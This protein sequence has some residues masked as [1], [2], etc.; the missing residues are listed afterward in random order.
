MEETL[1]ENLEET[2]ELCDIP[3][4]ATDC[5]AAVG[6]AFAPLLLT[7]QAGGAFLLACLSESRGPESAFFWAGVASVL[8]SALVYLVLQH[9][10][11]ETSEDDQGPQGPSLLSRLHGYAAK[12]SR[13]AQLYRDPVQ[14]ASFCRVPWLAA[15]A[16][17]GLEMSIAAANG[18]LLSFLKAM[19]CAAAAAFTSGVVL[20]LAVDGRLPGP[21]APVT[22]PET[23]AATI[24]RCPAISSCVSSV[25]A[26]ALPAVQQASPSAAEL[27]DAGAGKLQLAEK[28]VFEAAELR[29]K[30]HRRSGK[31]LNPTAQ[32]EK[33]GVKCTVM[34][35]LHELRRL[36]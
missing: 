25:I 5:I 4:D 12:L 19:V 23:A 7:L 30:L 24:A 3:V 15:A 11:G 17:L 34:Y 27:R 1:K 36:C 20:G 10:R 28:Y 29:D 32:L 18:C 16:T 26:L 6:I 22:Y 33:L 31:V 8:W 2:R 14:R 9:R 13:E 35:H 21:P